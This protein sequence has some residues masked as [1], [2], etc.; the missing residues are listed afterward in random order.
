[1]R[2]QPNLREDGTGSIEVYPS[3]TKQ[4]NINLYHRIT[5]YVESNRTEVNWSALGSQSPAMAT[6]YASGL[7]YAAMLASNIQRDGLKALDGHTV[8]TKEEAAAY[9]NDSIL[10][11]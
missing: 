4:G 8:V 11:I 7:S 3:L 5:I 9:W 6:H 10:P 1:M 2:I